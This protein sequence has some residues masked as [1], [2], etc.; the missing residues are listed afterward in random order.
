MS[1]PQF[2]MESLLIDSVESRDLVHDLIRDPEVVELVD[3]Y[4]QAKTNF[5]V[6]LLL[7]QME[8]SKKA[9]AVEE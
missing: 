9:K 5:Y 4:A 2:V 3:Q 6:A 1:F 7:R 8:P